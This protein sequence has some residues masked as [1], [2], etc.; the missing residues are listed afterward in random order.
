MNRPEL[1]EENLELIQKKAESYK[2]KKLC[3]LTKSKKLLIL[4]LDH[5]LINDKWDDYIP[6]QRPFL[7]DLL[8]GVYKNYNIATESPMSRIMEVLGEMRMTNH[9]DYR[10]AVVKVK[11]SEG[12]WDRCKP[13]RIIW[14]E[15]RE[16][17]PENTIIID[18]IRE[19][20]LMNPQSGLAI[21]K[22][23]NQKND[24]ELKKLAKYLKKISSRGSFKNLEHSNW[25]KLSKIID[26]C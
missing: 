12:S 3:R 23:N 7:H 24:E 19:N 2:I 10:K 17:G 14:H 16:F 26:Q 20:F 21:R 4:D 22:F 9:K 13:L 11:D 5:T 8:K 15:L 1:S 18:D 25:E 6:L